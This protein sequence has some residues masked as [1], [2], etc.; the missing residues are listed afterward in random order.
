MDAD[1][2][3]DAAG[4]DGHEYVPVGGSQVADLE[5]AKEERATCCTMVRYPGMHSEV[6]GTAD[7]VTRYKTVVRIGQESLVYSIIQS[8]T[9]KALLEHHGALQEL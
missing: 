8:L 5:A 6:H 2:S 4:A 3:S 7:A 9:V 1:E